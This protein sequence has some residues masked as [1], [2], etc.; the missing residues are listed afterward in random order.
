MYSECICMYVCMYIYIYIYIYIHMALMA[1]HVAQGRQVNPA[2]V[3]ICIYI[4]IY[5]YI[6]NMCMYMHIH[7]LLA[8]NYMYLSLSMYMNTH[9][10]TRN[11]LGNA[12]PLRG[13]G[14]ESRRRRSR[15]LFRWPLMFFLFLLSLL[16]FFS[17]RASLPFTSR[18]SRV[19]VRLFCWP[20]TAFARIRA[21]KPSAKG[22]AM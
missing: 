10:H 4:Y 9:T 13:S 14:F 12:T 2:P 21:S 20:L 18:T 6:C 7:A 3:L 11:V 1:H 22:A 15:R 16:D 8:L 5:V 19:Q 17:Q